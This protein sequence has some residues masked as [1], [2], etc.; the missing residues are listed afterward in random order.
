MKPNFQY[1]DCQFLDA[2]ENQAKLEF[3]LAAYNPNPV[4]LK[5]IVISYELF[6]EGKRF[7]SGQD[8]PIDLV[9]KDTVMLTLP[10]NVVYREIIA[11]GGPLAERVLLNGKTLP[12]R[13]DAVMKGNPTL[14]NEIEEGG[15]FSFSLSISRTVDIP[16][17]SAVNKAKNSI[18]RNLKKLF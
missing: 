17:E 5:N 1:H 18:R 6:Y 12:I 4:G 10:A 16:I 14:Y 7:L 8:M 2:N 9:P 15:L 3:K 13:M 11:V